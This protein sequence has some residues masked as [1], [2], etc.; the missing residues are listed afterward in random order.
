MLKFLPRMARC[1][2]ERSCAVFS[3]VTCVYVC[4]CL[5]VT[6]VIM[7]HLGNHPLPSSYRWSIVTNHLSPIISEIDLLTSNNKKLSCRQDT[8]PYCL[9][10]SVLGSRVWPF[11]VT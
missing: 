11:G 2:A 1:Y 5:S 4:P 10:A 3:R 7:D 9:T 6:L 8:R